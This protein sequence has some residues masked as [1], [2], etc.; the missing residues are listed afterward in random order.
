M[1][2]LHGMRTPKEENAP[3]TSKE[4]LQTLIGPEPAAIQ[5]IQA[6]RE[7]GA[8]HTGSPL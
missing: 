8:G 4:G 1:R 7:G 6:I 2:Q 3:Q 5:T